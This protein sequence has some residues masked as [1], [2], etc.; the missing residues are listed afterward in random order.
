MTSLP[1]GFKAESSRACFP[2]LLDKSDFVRRALAMLPSLIDDRSGQQ[3]RGIEFADCKSFQ[4]RL[5]PARKALQL[6]S[7]HIPELDINAVRPALAEEENGHR[8]SLKARRRKSKTCAI[9]SA[10]REHQR[11]DGTEL[12]TFKLRVCNSRLG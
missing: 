4:P 9:V 6:R 5:L 10:E 3:L 8:N 11:F 1:E 2:V 7:F 12:L